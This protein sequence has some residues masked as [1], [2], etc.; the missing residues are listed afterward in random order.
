MKQIR[1]AENLKRIREWRGL[2]KEE[3]GERIG[4]S[5]VNIGY[6]ETGR[7]EPRMGKVEQ[8]AEILNVS[9]DD[10]L[11]GY[12]MNEIIENSSKISEEKKKTLELIEKLS[13]EDL[14]LINALLERTIGKG[15]ENA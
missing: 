1:F 8:I 13:D 9:T 14:K 6:W 2:T 10:L 4:V 7:N 5:G 11:F 15:D 3:L 12:D